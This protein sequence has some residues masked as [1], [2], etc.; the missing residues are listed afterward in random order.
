MNINIEHSEHITI[1][2]LTESAVESRTPTLIEV[3]E[4]LS[5]VTERLPEEMF[6]QAQ[7]DHPI[8]QLHE[9][10]LRELFRRFGDGFDLKLAIESANDPFPLYV[11]RA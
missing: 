4:F 5:R 10:C 9:A 6:E 8:C 1:P 3:M 7:P 2:G 11:K